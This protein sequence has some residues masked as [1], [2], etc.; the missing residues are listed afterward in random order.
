VLLAC[1]P[2]QP[3][4]VGLRMLADRFEL[5]GWK[6]YFLGADV[7]EHELVAAA[8][9]LGPDLVVLSASTHFNRLELRDVVDRVRPKLGGVELRVS[10]Y[11]FARTH[12]GWDED[13][14]LDLDAALGAR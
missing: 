1:A 6:A 13:E 8:A 5:A 14:I 11:A 12:E 3:H 7:P 2:Q 10:G 9:A 4:D